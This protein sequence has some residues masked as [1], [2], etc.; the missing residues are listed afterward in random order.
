MRYANKGTLDE[1][2]NHKGVYTAKVMLRA[3]QKPPRFGNTPSV[4]LRDV[5]MAA[6]VFAQG[7]GERRRRRPY[8]WRQD[9]EQMVDKENERQREID[10][11][12]MVCNLE[13]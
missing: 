12:D 6:E 3:G 13:V 1:K 8:G 4:D 10:K 5:N 2:G 7:R 9:K 11:Q